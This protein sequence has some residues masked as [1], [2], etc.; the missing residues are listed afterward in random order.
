MP[1]CGRERAA[2]RSGGRGRGR[3]R[4]LAPDAPRSAQRRAAR[5]L[6]G[7]RHSPRRAAQGSRAWRLEIA[8]LGS[9]RRHGAGMRNGHAGLGWRRDGRRPGNASD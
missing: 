6:C 8:G 5:V 9:R 3:E 4:G 2:G 7:S 1:A